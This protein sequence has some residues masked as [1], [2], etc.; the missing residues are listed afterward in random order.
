M[1]AVK[2]NQI[3]SFIK[4][5][6]RLFLSFLVYGPDQGL[7]SERASELANILARRENPHGE[8]IRIDEPDLDNEPDKI[9][10]ELQTMPMFG[11]RKI[12]RTSLGRRINY[13]MLK[14]F[15]GDKTLSGL[16]IVEAG[17]LRSDESLRTSFE[18]SPQ[19]ASISCYADEGRDLDNLIRECLKET[20]HTILPD[21]KNSLV[22]RL[23]A[24]RALSRSE[25]EKLCL[26][27][28]DETEITEADIEAVV[29][30]AAEMTIEKIVNA[31][32]NRD[33]AL[34]VKELGRALSGG[35]KAQAILSALQR[36]FMRLHRV[37]SSIDNGAPLETAILELRPP[38]HFKQK[39]VFVSQC[40]S[41]RND[42]LGSALERINAATQ[43]ARKNA[44]TEN[45]IAEQIII[46]I[47]RITK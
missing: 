30:D 1:V 36:H 8:I 26:Y 37:R 45:I 29:G 7:V 11:G 22:S 13:Q 38:I 6:D 2:P 42:T 33:A 15:I 46:E 5:P 21:V 28:G 19:A 17:S 10:I 35:E 27:A 44:A 39:D 34:A 25:L 31:C 14:S 47:T 4:N 43:S 32:A 12:I 18:K 41:W 40:K 3:Q 23:G 20:G 9:A 16:L 24:D